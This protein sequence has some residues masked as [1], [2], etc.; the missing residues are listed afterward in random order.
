M[1]VKK[2][3]NKILHRFLYKIKQVLL[4]IQEGESCM[5]GCMEKK[6]KDIMLPIQDYATVFLENTLRDA[7]FVLKNTFYAGCAE[8]SQAHRSV[9]VFNSKKKLVGTLGFKEVMHLLRLSKEMP[10]NRNELFISLC[11]S[12]SGKKV[13][14]VMAPIGSEFVNAEDSVL[15]AAHLLIHSGLDLIPVLEKGNVVGMIRSAEIFK[16][17]SQLLE[18]NTF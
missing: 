16:E 2:F 3:T 6:V 9:L 14:D 5:P 17:V 12:Q 1:F 7:V 15:D 11:I 8:G 4:R 10:K 18:E 13:K